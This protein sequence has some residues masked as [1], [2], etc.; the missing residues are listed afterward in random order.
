MRALYNQRHGGL[1]VLQVR[2]EPDPSPGQGEVLVRVARAGLNFADVQARMGLYLDAPRPPMVMG[3]EVSGTVEAL[4]PGVGGVER[5]ARVLALT[6][7]G[8]QA[9]HVVVPAWQLFP[10]PEQMT[11][12]QGAALP[13]NY[14]TA[15]H[16]LHQVGNLH[17]GHRVLIHMAAGGVGLAAIQ[18]ARRIDDVTLFGTASARK[19]ALLREAGLQHPIDYRTTDYVAEVQRLTGGKG[20]HLVLDALG[21]RDWRKGYR[22]LAPTGHLIAFGFANLVTGTRRNLAS[23]LWRLLT[24][25]RFSPIPLMN[26]NRSVSGVNV[27]HL[28]SEPE[29]MASELRQLLQLYREGR[30]APHVDKVF[31]LERAAEAHQY[32]QDR[33][34]VGKVLL[35]CA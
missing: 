8:G 5:G 13:V 23:V 1:E 35:D 33:Q 15:F 26:E 4:G 7:F 34:N 31:P 20:V 22:L 16:M 9:S 29:L 2:E 14:L 10:M 3:Y 12:E 30:L 32:I 28:W 27:G 17:P 19:H 21:G 6:R 11:F 18:L 25:P 24:V